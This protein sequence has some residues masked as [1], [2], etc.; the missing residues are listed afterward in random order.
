MRFFQY[1]LAAGCVC[2]ENEQKNT[3]S[4]YISLEKVAHMSRNVIKI[5]RI[6]EGSSDIENSCNTTEKNHI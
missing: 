2:C 4:P 1:E 5:P 6:N 3:D